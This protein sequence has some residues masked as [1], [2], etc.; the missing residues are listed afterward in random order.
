MQSQQT[1]ER[2][3]SRP[4]AAEGG[5]A[6]SASLEAGRSAV[7][8]STVAPRGSGLSCPRCQRDTSR[9]RSAR[10][11]APGPHDFAVRGSL[12]VRRGTLIPYEDRAAP[13]EIAAAIAS[14]AL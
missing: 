2:T 3:G 13:P 14:R 9:Q 1:G 8:F 11:A 4:S 12:L 6:S 5:G 10:V 7:Y